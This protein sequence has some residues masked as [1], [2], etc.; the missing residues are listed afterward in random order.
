M[1]LE[2]VELQDRLSCTE[3]CAVQIEVTILN[4]YYEL[5]GN[6]YT[7]DVEKILLY[8]HKEFIPVTDTPI[9]DM[10]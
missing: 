8:V 3:I 4:N 9:P 6:K 1:L 10:A 5:N 7:Y 2:T